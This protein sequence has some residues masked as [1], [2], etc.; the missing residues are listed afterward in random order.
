MRSRGSAQ[1]NTVGC[2]AQVGS[3][4]MARRSVQVQAR[5]EAFE[6]NGLR[7]AARPVIRGNVASSSAPGQ[8]LAECA[9]KEGRPVRMINRMP[10][11][12]HV[13]CGGA[14]Q[15]ALWRRRGCAR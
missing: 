14:V 10:V 2:G 5:L 15:A 12:R 8:L 4:T 9:R 11:R 3:L 6:A 7:F 1:V 13:C